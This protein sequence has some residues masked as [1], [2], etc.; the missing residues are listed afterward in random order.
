MLPSDIV[1]KIANHISDAIDTDKTKNDEMNYKKWFELHCEW[2][3][4][5]DYEPLGYLFRNVVDFY[6]KDIL[7]DKTGKYF[8]ISRRRVKWFLL[9]KVH[10]DDC[11]LTYKKL[12]NN[13]VK[14]KILEELTTLSSKFDI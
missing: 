9:R 2:D 7:K 5:P 13:D 8:F 4:N 12:W 6:Y 1:H 14:T 10:L 11:T 3:G